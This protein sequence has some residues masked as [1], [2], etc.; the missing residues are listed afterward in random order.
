MTQLT[1]KAKISEIFSSIQG[2]GVYQGIAQIFVRFYGC[3][4][5]CDYCDTKLTNFEKYSGLEL[6][7]LIHSYKGNFHSV[8]LTGGEP[9]LQADFLEDF[10]KFLKL[11]NKTIYLETNGTLFEEL[12]RIIDNIDIVAMDF[13]LPSASQGNRFWDAHKDFLNVAKQKDLFV[14]IVITKSTKK[15]ELDKAIDLLSGLN[16]KDKV[17]LVLQPNFFETDKFLI[18]RISKFQSQCLREIKDV[19]IIPQM[20]KILRVK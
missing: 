5:N 3:N 4:L 10:L 12:N 8:C 13:K 17:R 11:H 1:R 18:N 7:N 19:R 6:Y 9:L 16:Y 14:K 15:E 20:H 2:E